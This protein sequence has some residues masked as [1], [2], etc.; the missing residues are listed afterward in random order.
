MPVQLPPDVTQSQFDAAI[1]AMRKVVGAE[2][3]FTSDED[4]HLYRDAYSPL[5]GE[6][7]E[8]LPSGAV[9]PDS[10][11][12]VQEIV[13]IANTYKLPLWPVSTGKNLG[14]GGSAPRLSGTV[15]LDLKRMN[16]VIEVNE[17]LAYALVEPGVSY[18]DLYRHLQEHKLKLWVDSADP[19]WGSVIGNALDHGCGHMQYRDHF[20]SHCGM[21]VVLASGEIMRT[22]MGALPDSPSWSTFKYGFGPHIST[23]FGQSNFG[24][25]T[26]MGIWLMP[27][28]QA[29]RNYLVAVPK[30]RDVVPLLR[31]LSRFVATGIIDSMWIIDSPLKS[32]TDPQVREL[33]ARDAPAEQLEQIGLAKGL[34]FWGTRL[35]FYGPTEIVDAHWQHVRE[36]LAEIPGAT[37]KDG[38]AYLSP[39]KPESAYEAADDRFGHA[40][41]G[42]PS[43]GIFT[44][45]A[46]ARSQGHIFFS[47]VIPMT[48]E[49]F[50]KAQNVFRQTFK[51]MGRP[52]PPIVTAGA[53]YK[54]NLILL[55]GIPI[56]HDVAANK[57]VRADV[58]HLVQVAAAN[59]WGEYRTPTVFMDDVMDVF[60]FNDHALLRF[61]QSIKDAVDPNGILAPGKSGI[62]P[63]RF[64]R[65]RS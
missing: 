54:R 47:P 52:L 49:Q 28:P 5:Q 7:E 32:S 58:K 30:E 11:E 12:Q 35:R 64:R 38:A 26:K 44:P 4:I 14:Y 13:R 8:Y 10:V 55:F 21:E 16:R 56:T 15:V 24:I 3:V 29:A 48:G 19:G 40:A 9:A 53:W 34:G 31:H 59:G 60:S 17:D 27:E 43:L 42:I 22:G 62:W 65:A 37:F 39:I 33:I 57:K 46:A 23:I 61:H 1:K 36:R 51:E 63:Q 20:D 50:L 41:V 2:W 25:V 45:G 18:F 6:E